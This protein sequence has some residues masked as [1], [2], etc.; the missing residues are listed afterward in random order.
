M[1]VQRDVE[2][3]ALTEP[4]RPW[5]L[6]ALVGLL[7]AAA[8]LP[9]LVFASTLVYL[10]TLAGT[11]DA[12]ESLIEANASLSRVVMTELSRSTEDL[13]RLSLAVSIEGADTGLVS[14]VA[15]SLVGPGRPFVA[16]LLKSAQGE[17]VL[18]GNA[19][20]SSLEP[21]GQAA[22][23]RG[24]TN[25]RRAGGFDPGVV[26][27]V[28][29]YRAQE[30][31]TLVGQLNLRRLARTLASHAGERAFATVLDANDIIIARSTDFERY[32]G[33]LPSQE[34]R[35]AIHRSVSGSARFRTRDGRE[36]LWSWQRLPETDWV[37]FLG[38]Q[39]QE[40]DA[41]FWRSLR[42]LLLGAA[43]ALALGTFAAWWVGRRIVGAV[44]ELTVQTPGLVS[45]RTTDYRPSGLKQVDALY[46]A[47]AAAG[48]KLKSAQRERDDALVS[49]QALRE[50]AERDNRMKDQFIATLSHELRNPLA[51]IV[52]SATLLQRRDLA[53]SQ[54]A[55]AAAVIGRQSRILSHLLDDL[56]DVARLT[57][58][59]V[60]LSPEATLVADVFQ[61][62]SEAV[63]PLMLARQHELVIYL[64]PDDLTV[65][66]DKVRLI[67][68]TANLLNNAAKYT[69][70][71]GRIELS[72]V[73]RGEDD[74]LLSVSDDGIGIPENDLPHLFKL[75]QQVES[76]RGRAEGGLGIGL[77][78][79]KGLVELHGGSVRASSGGR[80][81][82][83][84]FD[85]TLRRSPPPT[86]PGI[87]HP[88][89]SPGSP[90]KDCPQQRHPPAR[91][92]SPRSLL[93]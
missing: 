41:A 90:D 76:D 16:I 70:P 32:V 12:K 57:T 72:A 29:P 63:R 80:G 10:L 58:G 21:S 50:I 42:Q 82:G 64:R 81:R 86:V 11:D 15:S 35:N 46:E 37:V 51:P 26:E 89:R 27:I 44:D 6:L 84:R 7:P 1:Q 45:G 54:V 78:L 34:T 3:A 88:A 74:V 55:S 69:D 91:P 66:G 75:F 49:E 56:L 43:L 60:H 73:A 52:T 39:A 4:R 23:E 77:F 14:R 59:R 36:L 62:A 9:L 31:S 22:A 38:T 13:E 18:A 85:V 47:M 87:T 24:I 2:G 61:A 67:Q 5:D 17:Q 33:E 28:T 65:F 48:N 30:G 40:L 93:R 53:P 20:W 79:V 83:T 8:V 19:Q 68:V 71:G 92:A 25:F